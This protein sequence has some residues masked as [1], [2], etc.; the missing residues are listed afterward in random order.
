M[1]SLEQVLRHRQLALWR[2]IKK[3]YAV[4]EKINKK[5]TEAISCGKFHD[6]T[7]T[8]DLKVVARPDDT[9][10]SHHRS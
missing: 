4:P 3:H 9:P 7:V 6:I 2:E 1:E 5:V 8:S 10:S